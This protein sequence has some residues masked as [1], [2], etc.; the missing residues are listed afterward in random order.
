MHEHIKQ[1]LCEVALP[2]GYIRDDVNQFIDIATSEPTLPGLKE[3]NERIARFT[4]QPEGDYRGL[5]VR[6]FN[7]RHH[8]SRVCRVMT[9]QLTGTR[10]VDT[11]DNNQEMK[12]ALSTNA[13][14][15]KVLT[16]KTAK[17]AAQIKPTFRRRPRS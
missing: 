16:A 11:N 8:H 7:S 17:A 2:F 5:A 4:G 14:A 1:F 12:V 15:P 9:T 6:I 10:R 13:A 3:L